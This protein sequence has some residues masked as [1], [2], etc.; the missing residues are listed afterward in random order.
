MKKLH[1]YIGLLLCGF[2]FCISLTG[3]LLLI[4]KEYLWLSIP[5]ARASIDQSDLASA[6]ENI[7]KQYQGVVRFVQLNSQDLSIHKVFLPERNYA[8]HDQNGEQLRIWQGNE[9]IED[10]LLDLHHRFLLG[11]T[12][13]L[14]MAGASGLLLL[15]LSV[16]GL[17]LWWPYRRFWKLKI[18]F[19]NTLAMARNSHTNLGVFMVLPI[20]LIA[21][22]GVIL[23]Y[24][25]ESRWLLLNG[26]SNNAPV[27]I[28]IK[29]RISANSWQAQIDFALREFPGAQLRWLRPENEDNADRAIGLSQLGA[30]DPTGKTTLNFT[31]SQE[32]IIKDARH[33]RIS[34]RAVEL[35]YPLHVG[36][37]AFVYRLLLFIAGLALC[38]LSFFGFRSFCLRSFGSRR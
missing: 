29:K 2:I 28:V 1:R 31:D 17:L 3:S 14:N 33:Q 22:T 38:A 37:I 7:Y 36:S 34:A 23:V 9:A 8:F 20:L 30:W 12:I 18:S 5:A 24:P 16:I 11:N 13:G 27:P 10:W 32:V 21:V 25:A 35:S 26:F 19:S 6:M 4:K 15:P